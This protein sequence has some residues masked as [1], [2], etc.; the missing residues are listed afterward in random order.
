MEELRTNYKNTAKKILGFKQKEK[1]RNKWF[2]DDCK[3]ALEE[4]DRVYFIMLRDPNEEN[5]IQLANM[6]REAEKTLRIIKR[7]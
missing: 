4:R 6:Q 7:Q 5:K 1:K 2:D 3:K